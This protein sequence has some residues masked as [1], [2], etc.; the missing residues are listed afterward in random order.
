MSKKT[1]EIIERIA[2]EHCKKKFGYLT[3]D[4]LRGEIW[5]I[6]L[7]KL[8]DFDKEHGHLENFLRVVVHNRLINRFKDITKSVRSPCPRCPFYD[9]GG[10]GD[11]A[12]F[13]NDK[14]LCDKWR[15]YQ[16]SIVSRNSLLNASEPKIEKIQK[17]VID[18]LLEREKKEEIIA[19]I[20]PS[21][22]VD[23]EQLL[24]GSKIPKKRLKALKKEVQRVL[25]MKEL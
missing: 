6:C 10:P 2:K 18:S 3:E 22:V 21:F 25:D 4:D 17:S 8:P 7:E 24:I 5:K 19:L 15:N 11:C 23:I 1:F 9:L 14:Y 20:D 13:E 12:K 16:L